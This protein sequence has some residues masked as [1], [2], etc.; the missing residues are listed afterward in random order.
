MY[1]LGTKHSE[2]QRRK[3]RITD[4]RVENTSG[5]LR[6]QWHSMPAVSTSFVYKGCKQT[7]K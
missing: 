7:K 1:R 6:R 3:C 2:K 4:T 5:T